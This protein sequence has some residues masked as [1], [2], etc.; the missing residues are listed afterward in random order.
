MAN[1]QH[2]ALFKQG[3]AI[4]NEWRR[5]NPG[6]KDKLASATP[7]TQNNQQIKSTPNLGTIIVYRQWSLGA[8]A[9]PD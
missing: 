9:R 5:R 3:T 1:A 2:L 7:S 6:A 8:A 4:W